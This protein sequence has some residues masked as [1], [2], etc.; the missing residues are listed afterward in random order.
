MSIN[1][2]YN[3][4]VAVIIWGRG[5]IIRGIRGLIEWGGSVP[6]SYQPSYPLTLSY[7]RHCSNSL[8]LN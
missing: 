7:L 2:Y 8:F 5:G 4:I 6:L 1:I 3:D